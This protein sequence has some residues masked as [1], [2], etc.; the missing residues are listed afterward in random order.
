MFIK[1]TKNSRN[2]PKNHIYDNLVK[3]IIENKGLYFIFAG[4]KVL[5]IF[6]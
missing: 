6:F 3:L 5:K 4:D 2:R 1:F